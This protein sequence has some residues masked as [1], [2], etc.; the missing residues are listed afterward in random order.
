LYIDTLEAWHLA[1]PRGRVG[2][3]RAL[4]QLYYEA[5]QPRILAT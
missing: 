4:A 5:K 3:L 2:I 1:I